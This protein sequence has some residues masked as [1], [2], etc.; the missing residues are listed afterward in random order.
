MS[1]T[2]LPTAALID[3]FI[4]RVENIVELAPLRQMMVHMDTAAY[5]HV[6]ERAVVLGACGWR[7][8][9]L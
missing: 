2:D 1:V 9:P 8:V 3:A 7:P 6:A 4:V 5:V